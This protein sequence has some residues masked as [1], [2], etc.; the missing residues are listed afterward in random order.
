M[1]GVMIHPTAEVQT[2]HIGEGS[3]VWQYCVVLE[4][5]RIGK[6]C[7]LNCHVFVENDVVLGN[8]VTIKSGVQLW[9]GLRIEDDV[10]VGPNVTFTNDLRP[11]SGRHLQRY[12][13]TTLKKGAS[14]G[15]KSVI[16]GSK[17]IGR[18]AM[19]GA[20]SV[21]THDIPDNTLWYGN[22]ARF[23]GYICTCGN[24]LDDEQWCER[25]KKK[26]DIDRTLTISSQ[27]QGLAVSDRRMDILGRISKKSTIYENVKLG[28]D[29]TICD[30]AVIYS[31]V[32]IGD[33]SFIGQGCIIGEPLAEFYSNRTGY[34]NPALIIGKNSIIRSHSILYAGSTIGEFFH[35]GHKVAIREGSQFGK[36]CSVG[37]YS[38]IQG[39]V[40]VGDYCRF[41]SSVHISQHT[42]IGS[43]VFIFPN[44]VL[45]NDPHP[46]STCIK[47]PILEDYC[48]I[49]AGA[50][51]MP[52]ITIGK[53]SIVGANSLAS[54]D[55]PPESVVMGVPARRICSIHDIKCQ[56]GCVEKPYPWRDH[57][58]RGMPW[59]T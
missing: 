40:K 49:S 55:V 54:K 53:D 41:H 21:V 1:Q 18:Y 36:N 25:C 47:G 16:V 56:N 46:P 15:A 17:T 39:H 58:S 27:V 9:D 19:V 8:N 23:K 37:T 28:K 12:L 20:G 26:L 34:E 4:G 14:I 30:D 6:K 11:R 32:E 13:Q 22:P 10:F 48:I 52:G 38:D 42:L 51:L 59:G 35:T 3:C 50:I 45:T 33:G 31:N 2:K 5:A 43:Y 29:V 57:F 44:A 24:K 7:N